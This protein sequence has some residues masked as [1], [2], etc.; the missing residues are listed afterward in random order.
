MFENVHYEAAS[1]TLASLCV[2]RD[3]RLFLLS[4]LKLWL[5]GALVR[6]FHRDRTFS[7]ARM[8][9]RFL[10]KDWRNRRIAKTQRND[11]AVIAVPS[12]N[13]RLKYIRLWIHFLDIPI[14]LAGLPFYLYQAFHV[15][16][17]KRHTHI[18]T[19]MLHTRPDIAYFSRILRLRADSVLVKR[20][21]VLN[22]HDSLILNITF[23]SVE[24]L[25]VRFWFEVRSTR[26]D[27]AAS[28]VLW[29]SVRLMAVK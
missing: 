29:E 21:H 15:F 13:S 25:A 9:G 26:A 8:A 17:L 10:A 7:L 3:I 5:I 28:A 18:H 22:I 24:S 4:P 1:T 14:P 19:H 11:L 23:P 2:T 16:S 20:S 27:M 12:Y 6:S